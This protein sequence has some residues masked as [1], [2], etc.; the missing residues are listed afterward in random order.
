M[1]RFWE[2][3]ELMPITEF[4]K[5]LQ[6]VLKNEIHPQ[7]RSIVNK[8]F[9][10]WR[11]ASRNLDWQ[12]AYAQQGIMELLTLLAIWIVVLICMFV[13]LVCLGRTCLAV[14]RALSLEDEEVHLHREYARNGGSSGRRGSDDKKRR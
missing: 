13:G 1:E 3:F 4:E 6:K 8:L 9:V 14:C 7:Q 2:D 10:W 12:I 5:S 11:G